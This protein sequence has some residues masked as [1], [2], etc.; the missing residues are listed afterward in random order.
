[1]ELIRGYKYK[2]YPT[3]EQ[4]TLLSNHCF[5]ANQAFNIM[6]SLN[7]MLGK[8]PHTKFDELISSKCKRKGLVLKKV[9]PAYT[10]I[11]GIL[12]YS[13]RDNLQIS[14]HSNSKD[15]SAALVI[16]RRGLGLHEKGIISVRVSKPPKR[17]STEIVSMPIKSLLTESEKEVSTFKSNK[18][19][20][21]SLWKRIGKFSY[22]DLTGRISD[23][24]HEVSRTNSHSGENFLHLN[25]VAENL[26]PLNL[27]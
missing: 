15:L 4:A 17:G 6:V 26:L 14:H 12:K 23:K 9:N 16:G 18:Q 20:T 2:I 7:R 21:W 11:I 24:L 8:F 22:L 1:M 27:K 5:N 3:V 25:S 19:S 13:N 10:S